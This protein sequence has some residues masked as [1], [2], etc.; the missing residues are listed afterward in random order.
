MNLEYVVKD[1][2][3]YKTVR[4][5]LKSEFNMSN[6][7]ITKLKFNKLILLNS[8]ET[9][10]DKLL[11]IGDVV[12]C[13]LD[14]EEESENIVPTKMDLNILYEDDCF[15]IL[16]KSYNMPVH[17]SILHYD[18]SLSNGVKYYFDLI[19]LKKKIRP[20]NRL[21]RD[22]TGI[23]IFAKNEYIQE[24]LIKQMQNKTFYKEYLA[25]LNGVPNPPSGVIDVPIARKENSIIERCISPNGDSA[26]SCYK[27]I[28]T[29]S[30]S[31]ISLVRFVLKTGRTHQIRL[32]S[33][34]IGHPILGDTL[35]GVPS[36]L[37]KRQALHSYKVKFIH[38][39][40]KKS[41]EI[42]A[43]IPDDMNGA[44][45]TQISLD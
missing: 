30:K 25:I 13:S 45:G 12:Y 43:P 32:H 42:K 28:D 34:F 40:L 38:P 2:S 31:D 19:G 6:R 1:L 17:P 36:T 37:I 23:V 7:L 29:N 8:A 35:Y 9:Y 22:T 44:F 21:D 20:V 15:L 14:Y 41:I 39:I 16:N 10:L 4:Q 18:N 3:L 11:S 24:C 5:V 27:V 33:K 26:I